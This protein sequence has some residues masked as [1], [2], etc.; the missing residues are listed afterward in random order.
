[1]SDIEHRYVETIC[2]DCIIRVSSFPDLD[3]PRGS[4]IDIQLISA[5]QPNWHRR[6][7]TRLRNAWAVLRNR[8]DWSGFALDTRE[9]AE[10]FRVAF[11]RAFQNTWPEE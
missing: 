8:Y 7:R 3:D 6:W 4:Y 1:V 5:H 10:S 11:A 2:L 9:S